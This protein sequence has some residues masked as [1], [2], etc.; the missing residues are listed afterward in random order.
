M[1]AKAM[2]QNAGLLINIVKE[3]EQ[4]KDLCYLERICLVGCVLDNLIR[5]VEEL[6]ERQYIQLLAIKN[7]S[8]EEM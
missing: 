7:L 6:E 8:R 5:E 3:F 1:E 2:K 4:F